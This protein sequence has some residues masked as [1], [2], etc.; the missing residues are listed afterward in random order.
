MAPKTPAPVIQMIKFP[1]QKRWTS[2]REQER[3]GGVTRYGNKLLEQKE[4]LQQCPIVTPV[5]LTDH[6]TG[7][8]THLWDPT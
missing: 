3:Y 1:P 7:L 5:I 8:M 6:I 4:L 2:Y